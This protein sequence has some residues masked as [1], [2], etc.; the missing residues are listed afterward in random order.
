MSEAWSKP[1]RAEVE[2]MLVSV[3][4]LS[5]RSLFFSELENSEW[6]SPLTALGAFKSPPEPQLDAEGVERVL[7]WPQGDYL[8]RMAADEPSQV[9]KILESVANSANPWVQRALVSAASKLPADRAVQLVPAIVKIVKSSSSALLN[10]EDVLGVA[11]KLSDAGDTEPVKRLLKALFEPLRGPQEESGFGT[12]THV[13]GVIEDY[14]YTD[15]LPRAVPLLVDMNALEGLKLVADWLQGA[16]RISAGGRQSRPGYD[17]GVWRSS[18]APHPQNSGLHEIT[19]SLIDAVRD[20]AVALGCRGRHKDVIEFLNGSRTFVTRRIALEATSQLAADEGA[21]SELIFLGYRLLMDPT[22]MVITSRPEYVRLV[23]ALLPRLSEAQ[24]TSWAEFVLGGRWEGTDDE[25]RRMATRGEQNVDEVTDEEVADTREYFLHSLLQALT[26]ALPPSLAEAR[27]S[28]EQKRGKRDHAE[29]GS[30]MESFTGPTS[31][32]SKDEMLAMSA[33]DLVAFLL[34]WEPTGDR[35]FGPSFEGLAREFE[36]VVEAKPSFVAEFA[37]KL[38]SAGRSYIRAALAGWAKAVPGGYVPNEAVWSLVGAVV[39]QID[40]EAGT[41]EEHDFEAHDP[42]WAWAQRSAVDLIAA[43]ASTLAAPA[44]P[45]HVLKLWSLLEPLTRHPDPTVEH[46]ERYGGSN[47]DPMTFSLNTTRPAALRTA[48]QLAAASHG[49]ETKPG[50]PSALESEI[51]RAVASHLDLTEDPSLAVAAVIGEGL[52]RI[53]GIDPTWVA[54]R[55]DVLFSLLDEDEGRRAHSDVIVSVALRVYRTGSVFI[56]LIRPALEQIFTAEYA[57]VTH[58]EGWHER[59]RSTADSAAIQV[60]SAFLLGVIG[61]DDPLIAG[62]FASDV[63][64]GL[65]AE[66]LGHIGWQLMR[67]GMDDPDADIPVEYLARART[68]I[69][70]RVRE[71]EGGR[72]SAKELVQFFW[73]AR[74]NR[75]PPSWWLPILAIASTERDSDTRATGMLGGPLS[76]AAKIEPRLAIELFEKLYDSN[77]K[78]W[79]GYDLVQHAAGILFCALRSGDDAAAA[80]A[81]RIKDV[82]GR[83][84]HFGALDDLEQL[85]NA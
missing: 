55:R 69:D 76:E 16:A 20:T 1:T 49:N 70:W 34:D 60:L 62:I 23:N 11:S 51:L 9:A 82:L 27:V 24:Q 14:F 75:F 18:I 29:F 13:R 19:D 12:R 4:D 72:A 42:V 63:S 10:V 50:N 43:S 28:L 15:N 65:A 83:Q 52:G 6:L 68:L 79:R 71:I 32:K 45:Q 59:R 7:P 66:A 61:L 38:I 80:A 73:W 48:I 74:A 53:W 57:R 25:M 26:G 44:S 30:Y 84:G 40:G 54:D 31:P 64:S 58:T 37:D 85:L 39:E 3:A 5:L 41:V 36:L 56:E 2:S 47:M 81:T 21:P 8:V 78:N 46:E 67:T 17:L 77:D 35:H 33:D 22:L